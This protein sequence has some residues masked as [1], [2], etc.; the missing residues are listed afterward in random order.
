MCFV[1]THTR[2]SYKLSYSFTQSLAHLV[3]HLSMCSCVCYSILVSLLNQ[4]CVFGCSS[5]V[6]Y[7]LLACRSFDEWKIQS[8]NTRYD[9]IQSC[10]HN[11]GIYWW[12]RSYHESH[13]LLLCSARWISIRCHTYSCVCVKWIFTFSTVCPKR[14][15]I[16]C[17]FVC[18]LFSK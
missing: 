8:H 15:S 4:L 14:I 11:I 16:L 9:I 17:L 3:R 6:V 12:E 13:N 10:R 18:L 5:K 7:M 2:T 1:W